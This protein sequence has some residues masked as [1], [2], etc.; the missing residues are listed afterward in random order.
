[1]VRRI[2]IVGGGSAGWLTAGLIAADHQGSSL[3]VTLIE[4][5]DIAPI[6]V[7]EGTWPSMRDTLRRIGVSEAD[8]FRECDASFKQ[9]SRFNCWVNGSD[10]DYYF[11]PFVLPQGYGEV[12][13]PEQWQAQ[14]P[15]IPFADLVSYQPHLCVNGRAPKQVVTPEFS[16]V[17]NYGYHLDAGKFGAFLRKHCLEKL[18][19]HYVPDNVVGI[20][21][22][23]NGD[24]AAL[25]TQT[26]GALEG[27]LFIDCTG[28]QSLL[29]GKHYEVPFLSQK[30]VL[31]ND[32]ALAVQIPYPD[33][34]YPIASQTSSTAQSA[35]W[36]WDIGLPTRRGIGHVYSSAHI[37]DEQA[38]AELRRYIAATGGPQDIPQPRKLSFN[39][40]YRERF[41]HRNCVAIGLS[42]GFIEPLEASALALVEMSAAMVSDELP[43]TRAAMDIVAQ[44]FNDAFSYR[45]ERVI[46]FLKLHY[47]LSQ[48]RDSDYWRDNTAAIPDRLNDLL[49]LWR[50]RAPSRND[51]NRIEEVFPSASYQYVLYG[52]GFRSEFMNPQPRQAALADGYFREAAALTHKMLGALPDNRELINHIKRHGLQK[53]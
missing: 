5:P 8:F 49:T 45:W 31:Y 25:Q 51:F 18:G 16:S 34:N 22:H 40:G 1:M 6:G 3:H 33:D 42:A 14:H 36:I 38:E 35:G 26:H 20:A 7:G 4:S 21:N 50:H 10:H 17:A 43:A 29:L 39:P 2:V 11:H 15:N 13:L 9:G 27:D 47:V 32:S 12:N 44:R 46:D 37:G 30:H 23:D 48:R 19:V 28:M 24:I 41:W 52:M 53:I